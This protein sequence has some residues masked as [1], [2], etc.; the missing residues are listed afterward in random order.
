MSKIPMVFSM[1]VIMVRVVS[2]VRLAHVVVSTMCVRALRMVELSSSAILPV[3]LVVHVLLV[4]MIDQNFTV[5][6]NIIVIMM[7]DVFL[8]AMVQQMLVQVD[9]MLAVEVRVDEGVVHRRGL[10]VVGLLAFAV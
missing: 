2:V 1:P 8:F 3:I 9:V 4:V 6:V 10:D 7:V 5:I